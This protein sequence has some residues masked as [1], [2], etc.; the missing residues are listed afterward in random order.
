MISFYG[1]DPV[2]QRERPGS[3]FRFPGRATASPT[4]QIDLYN[5]I[6]PALK[7]ESGGKQHIDAGNISGHWWSEVG[8]V[9]SPLNFHTGKEYHRP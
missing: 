1:A 9:V 8:E 4:R 7:S 6:L 2:R 3:L 5:H